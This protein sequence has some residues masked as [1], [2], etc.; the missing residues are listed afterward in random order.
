VRALKDAVTRYEKSKRLGQKGLEYKGLTASP[1]LRSNS[2]IQSRAFSN[3]LS[4][5]Q[6]PLL[7]FFNGLA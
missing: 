4:W 1:L 3:V 7:P 5:I 2:L 6:E